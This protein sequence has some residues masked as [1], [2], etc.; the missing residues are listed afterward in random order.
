LLRSVG[1]DFK[2]G[3][4]IGKLSFSLYEKYDSKAWLA[5]LSVLYFDFVHGWIRPLGSGTE[6]L[7]EACQ[8][9]LESGDIEFA[10]ACE[11]VY[12]YNHLESEKLPTLVRQWE[13][14]EKLAA[15]YGQGSALL[16][17]VAVRQW[18]QNLMD[19]STR[20]PHVLNGSFLNETRAQL[21]NSN[22]FLF[23]WTQIQV[24]LLNLLFGRYSEAGLHARNGRPLAANTYGPH[25]GGFNVFLCG[26]ADVAC[27]RHQQSG[28]ASY[29]KWCSRQLRESANR[30]ETLYFIGKHYLL[31][32]ELAALAG[33]TAN[34]LTFYII[35]VSTSQKAGLKMQ[36]ALANER[37][38][39]FL[40]DQGDRERSLQF[41]REA[42]AWYREW[43]ATVKAEH[44]ER[45]MHA[46]DLSH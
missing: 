1:R 45:E 7:K 23:A 32:A 26:F 18:M 6:R 24:A 37:T 35:A 31:E 10:L 14:I 44:L 17:T 33:K 27:A 5:R 13:L 19:K 36:T 2:E 4:R 30:G 39:R 20:H 42:L 38:A 41:Y 22:P 25:C 16:M 34:A 8:A 9:G 15:L 12:F 29:A 28:R 43:G 46:F 3:E 11:M 21:V 40:W